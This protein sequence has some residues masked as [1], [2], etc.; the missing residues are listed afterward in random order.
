MAFDGSGTFNRPV[1]SYVFDTVISE[2][3]VNAEMD[4][5]A[6][7]LSNCITK[8][9]QQP[10]TANIPF[11][12]FK[13]T[14]YGATS[15]PS[16]R[17]DVPQVG[18]VQDGSFVWC[19]TAGGTADAITLTPSPAITAYAAG[20]KFRW[21][22]GASPNTG[23]MTITVSGLTAKAAQNDGSA[24]VAGD[25]AAGK[26]YEGIYDG[27]AIQ[28]SRVRL[29]PILVDG[30]VTTAKIA[31]N[32]VTNA[33]SAQMA[34]NTIKGNNTASTAN[35]ADL[36][37]SQALAL[38]GIGSFVTNSLGADVTLNNV[39]TYFD[40]PSVNAGTT[41]TFFVSGTVCLTDT[42]GGATFTMKLWDGTTLIASARINQ[43]GGTTTNLSCALSG[44][45]TNPTGNLRISV[46]DGTNT[47]GKIL[48]NASGLGKDSTITAF[49]LG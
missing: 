28:T 43:A 32:A 7:G 12:G 34:A 18:Q 40:G 44:F 21:I 41:G 30:S 36:T 31:D 3:D 37:A 11:S 33:K 2:T 16:A 26:M 15:A 22:A 48:S 10:L 49:R 19:G 1:S 20:Q 27:T 4:G 45:I 23:A 8:D 9:G 35:A 47:A 24:L 46:Q 13:I 17:T 14:G 38:L 5:I 42:T 25:H 6:T 29:T 39:V